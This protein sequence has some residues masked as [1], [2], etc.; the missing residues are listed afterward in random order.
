[1]GSPKIPRVPEPIPANWWPCARTL[2]RAKNVLDGQDVTEVVKQ[3]HVFCR[4][5]RILRC[6]WDPTFLTW[7]RKGMVST[8]LPKV[9]TD[10]ARRPKPSV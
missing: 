1:M 7:L 6:Q 4:E 2:E 9:T 3:F 5:T 10:I 8:W